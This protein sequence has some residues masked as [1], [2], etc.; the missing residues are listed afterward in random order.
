MKKL[1]F[2]ILVVVGVVGYFHYTSAQDKAQRKNFVKAYDENGQMVLN[3]Q[4]KDLIK[5][6]SDDFGDKAGYVGGNNKSAKL[7]SGSKLSYT[8]ELSQTHPNASMKVKVYSNTGYI[9]ADN[10][11]SKVFLVNKLPNVTWKMSEKEMS[12]YNNPTRY[13]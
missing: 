6:M 5:Y 13:K 11:G 1:I 3:T 10:K 8:Y 12:I 7:P 9:T 2:L 4:N